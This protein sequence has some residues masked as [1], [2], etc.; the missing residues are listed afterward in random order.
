MMKEAKR[1]ECPMCGHRLMDKKEGACGAV[2]VKCIKSKHVW[3]VELSK[4][5]FKLLRGKL[6][7]DGKGVVMVDY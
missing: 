6:Y 7:P 1:I 2:Q 4:P 3:E 5:T